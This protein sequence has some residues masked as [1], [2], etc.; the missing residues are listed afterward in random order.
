MDS[1]FIWFDLTICYIVINVE[2]NKLG[3]STQKYIKVPAILD[4]EGRPR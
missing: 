2:K 1:H 4:A 3:E